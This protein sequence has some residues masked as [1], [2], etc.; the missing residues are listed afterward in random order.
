MK[1]REAWGRVLYWGQ[2]YHRTVLHA[3]QGLPNRWGKLMDI[4]NSSQ[5]SQMGNT[6]G[7]AR[8]ANQSLVV[9]FERDESLAGSLMGLLGAQGYESRS[10]KTPVEVF[11]LIARYP[12][13]LVLVNLGQAATGRREFWVALDSQ[14]RGRGVQVVTYRNIIPGV[15]PESLDGGRAALADVE[16]RGAQ[17]FGALID[18]VRARLPV[19]VRPAP[20]AGKMPGAPVSHAPDLTDT[21][22]PRDPGAR[23][24]IA[25]VLDLRTGA[26]SGQ[27]YAF[28]PMP[29]M[30]GTLAGGAANGG[31]TPEVTEMPSTTGGQPVPEPMNPRVA[32]GMAGYTEGQDTPAA[33]S[34]P[35][36]PAS[37]MPAMPEQKDIPGSMHSN[38]NGNGARIAQSMNGQQVGANGA[39]HVVQDIFNAPMPMGDLSGL[40]DAIHALAAAGAPGYHQAAAAANAMNAAQ[41]QGENEA[42]RRQREAAPTSS[43]AGGSPD[44]TSRPVDM[45]EWRALSGQMPGVQQGP[46]GQQNGRNPSE[47]VYM[48]QQAFEELRRSSDT[49][50]RS[51]S[52]GTD[53]FDFARPDTTSRTLSGND[54]DTFPGTGRRSA[55]DMGSGIGSGQSSTR[56]NQM[57]TPMPSATSIERSLGT[58]LVDG[59]LVSQQRLEVAMGIQRLLR[60]ADIDYRLGELL[61][62]FKFLTPDQLLAALLV[63]RGLVSPAQVAAMGRIKQELHAIGMQYDLENL[64]ILFRLLSSEQLREIRSEFP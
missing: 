42:S 31:W 5:G 15:E 38:G 17:G 30:P 58:V 61:L 19:P 48:G 21:R 57:L 45:N 59:Q 50:S 16:I 64:L 6:A 60:G 18:A 7:G 39:N 63:S 8:G 35:G 62:L 9:V 46:S 40:T 29:A 37:S 55:G 27:S 43:W 44:T 14:R 53:E 51:L 26:Q 47:T 52:R 54:E 41:T 25:G 36:R 20:D 49:R 22:Q 56:Q 12:V 1:R 4:A 10:A 2:F 33:A 28:A 3:G 32:Q 24:P 23:Q 13:G 11:D 34:M